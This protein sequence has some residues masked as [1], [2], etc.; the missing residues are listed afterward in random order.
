MNIQYCPILKPSAKEFKNF[1]QYV[2]FLDKTYKPHYGMVKIIPPAGWSARHSDYGPS[3]D[4]FIIPGPIEQNTYGKG[5][6][7]ECL[8]I[9][10]KSL[11]YKEYRK[12]TSPFDKIAE[13]KSA[14]EV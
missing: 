1:H 4:N 2:E 6:V 5:G 12:K 7:Y 8:H 10:K 11:S 13:G 3:I 9:Q 14:E